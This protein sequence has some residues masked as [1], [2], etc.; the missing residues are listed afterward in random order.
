MN[1]LTYQISQIGTYDSDSSALR[2]QKNFLVYLAIFMSLGGLTWG[3]VAFS[4]GLKLQ[5]LIPL[6]YI[7]ISM[8][9]MA[10]FWRFKRFKTARGFQILFSLLLPFVFQAS[11]G[12]YAPS[13]AMM[14]WSVLALV[15]S[16][17]FQDVNEAI[18]WF[19]LFISLTVMSVALD[20]ILFLHKPAILPDFSLLF[21][22]LN[23]LLIV[24][25]IFGLV[26]FYVSNKVSIQ[27]QLMKDVKE[28]D[29][30]IMKYRSASQ[31]QKQACLVLVRKNHMLRQSKEDLRKTLDEQLRTNQRLRKELQSQGSS[32]SVMV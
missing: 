1:Q 15:A 24:C 21:L 11:L 28:L 5:S 29:L 4:F 25:I 18:L 31:K 26:V 8:L 7:A 13:G 3:V 17:T 19:L 10:F 9:N 14:L 22:V 16:V 2:M 20:G 23:I 30:K 6:S 27:R 32:S 12:G